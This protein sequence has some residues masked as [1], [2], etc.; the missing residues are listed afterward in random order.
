MVFGQMPRL[1]AIS[2][3]TPLDTLKTALK[4]DE[5]TVS[6]AALLADQSV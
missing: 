4:L 6:V 3:A 2:G 5:G 1:D